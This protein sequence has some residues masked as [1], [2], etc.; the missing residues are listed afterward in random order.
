MN[1][2]L[3]S[4]FVPFSHNDTWNIEIGLKA[5]LL[6]A[7]HQVE[8]LYLPFDEQPDKIFQQMAL[9]RWINLIDLADRIITFKLPAH[10]IPHPNKVIWYACPNLKFYPFSNHLPQTDLSLE[11]FKG[12]QA[13]LIKLDSAAL[14]EARHIFTQSKL[15]SSCLPSFKDI[16]SEVLYPP[17]SNSEKFYNEGTNDEIISLG[18]STNSNRQS[19]LIEA[20]AHT[21][22]AVKLRIL[23]FNG[24]TDYYQEL[25][26]LIEKYNLQDRVILANQW[27]P[28]AEKNKYLAN[29]LAVAYLPYFASVYGA[30]TLEACYAAKPILTT[31]DSGSLL[32][33]IQPNINGA[34]TEAVPIALAEAMDKLYLE[35]KFSQQLGKT[36]LD[37][38]TALNINWQ[39]VLTRLL[40]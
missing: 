17:L 30:S 8:H 35:R 1:I 3:C 26:Q 14:I 6:E 34:V 15:I 7:G 20:M 40:A 22:T 13:G 37:S 11:E 10:L 24:F 33:I 2:I 28:E 19:L 12:I 16:S 29:C 25:I 38:I 4:T 9:Y 31:L 27:I 5:K 23:G 32:E 21:K 18:I 39:N 36:A